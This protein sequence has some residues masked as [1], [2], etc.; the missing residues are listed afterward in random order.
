M[1]TSWLSV[2]HVWSIHSVG[3]PSSVGSIHCDSTSPYSVCSLFKNCD[4]A[5]PYA[6]VGWLQVLNIEEPGGMSYKVSGPSH[7]LNDLQN[8]KK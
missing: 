7:M 2:E 1:L 4:N 6:V 5:V 3:P 8:L